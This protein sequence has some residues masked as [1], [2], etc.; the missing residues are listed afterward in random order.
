MEGNWNHLFSTIQE[1][2]TVRQHKDP[3]QNHSDLIKNTRSIQRSK[4]RAFFTVFAVH[5]SGMYN[6]NFTDE[7]ANSIGSIVYD[8]SD[9]RPGKWG[10]E[11]FSSIDCDYEY[12]S[13]THLV[14]NDGGRLTGGDIFLQKDQTLTLGGQWEVDSDQRIRSQDQLTGNSVL[15]FVNFSNLGSDN[16]LNISCY[17]SCL[18][19]DSTLVQY[20]PYEFGLFADISI[21][22]SSFDFKENPESAP[23]FATKIY[24]SPNFDRFEN[25]GGDSAI[26]SSIS[27]IDQTHIFSA[28]QD[29]EYTSESIWGMYLDQ[30]FH[31]ASTP[32]NQ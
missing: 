21:D 26:P 20:Y 17:D 22:S 4:H 31:S 29:S 13:D 10:Q 12:S 2:A 24:R 16:A 15:Q 25:K 9:Y 5:S 14:C 11:Q 7:A 19:Q 1:Y 23:H 6:F 32:G 30:G 28:G 27:D 18:F 3:L 8:K